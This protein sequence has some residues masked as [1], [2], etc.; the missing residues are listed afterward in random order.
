[1]AVNDRPTNDDQRVAHLHALNI[2]DTPREDAFDNMTR[3][4]AELFGVPIALVSL[5]DR[6]RQWFKSAQGLCSVQ[7]ARDISFCSHVVFNAAPLVVSDATQDPRFA[8]NPLVAGEPYIRFYAGVPIL[9]DGFI[10][11]TLCLIDTRA[12]DLSAA[13]LER[14]QLLALQVEQLILL[15][16]QAHRLGVEIDQTSTV[17]AQYEAIIQGAAAGVVRINGRGRMLEVNRFVCDML[18]YDEQE[19]LGQNVKMLMPMAYAVAHDGYLGAYQRSG[20]AKVIGK[21]REVEAQHGDGHS[22]PVHLA[23]SEVHLGAKSDDHDS[24]QFIGIISDLRDVHAAREREQKERALLEVLHHG[25]TDYRALVS[26]NTL[27]RFLKEALK[28]LTH[29]EYALIGEVVQQNDTPALKVHAITDLSWSDKSRHLM[30]QLVSGNMMLSSPSTMLG[31]VFAGGEIV[32]SNDMQNDPRGGHLPPGHPALTRYL[33]VPIVDRGRLIGMYAIANAPQD[34]DESLVEWLKPFTST[35][36]LLINLYRQL[37]E[38]DRF[39]EELRIAK[40]QAETASQAKTDFLSSMSH[41]LR[42]PLNSILGFAQLL[43]NSRTPLPERQKRQAGQIIRSGRHLLELINEV[44]DLARIES[45]NMQVSMEPVNAQD[46]IQDA[47]EII[48]PLAA[49]QG[50]KLH[51]PAPERCGVYVLGDYT[52]TKQVL[53]NL[54][55]NAVKYNRES[56]TVTLQC[57]VIG[58]LYRITVSDTGRG[59]P[60]SRLAELFQPFNRLG[61]ESGSIEGTG[62]GLVLTRQLIGLMQ[63]E[64]GVVSR[65]GEGS[66]FW[67]ELPLY[68]GQ[69]DQPTETEAVKIQA[70]LPPPAV[71]HRILY[72]EDNPANQRLIK[73]LFDDQA[74]IELICA[75]DAEQ[76]I[77][78]VFSESPDLIL[79]DIDL[80]GMSGF[81]AQQIL[82]RNPLTSKLPVL[83]I[84]ASASSHNIRRA[85][86]AGF[87]D[88]L[89]KPVDLL[90]LMQHVKQILS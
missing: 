84:S 20:E 23:V 61:A 46:V 81:D 33:G 68:N 57:E 70:D 48:Q 52:R 54:L 45:G 77:E 15:H 24:R 29:S 79:M 73:E 82:R 4:V 12:R 27:W 41:E 53:I 37:N 25:L 18:G 76:G 80:P 49:E 2:L 56:G 65:E 62:V 60:E 9:S 38:Q 67:F 71:S 88:Y 74:D 51:F 50:L 7:T 86:D 5:V 21:G 69:F 63:G 11:G 39:T 13:E 47:I 64:M 75:H 43:E 35:C 72:I 34:Y 78:L 26:G 30:E 16:R 8:A 40:E 90:A 55:S 42:T 66:D 59:I 83:A 14:L 22:I 1:M 32:L 17:N 44:L 89:T 3:L 87:I 85:R 19:L 28:E 10:L 58:D 6:E 31:R 36:A